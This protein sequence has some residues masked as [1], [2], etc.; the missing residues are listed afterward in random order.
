[1]LFPDSSILISYLFVLF[2]DSSIL[3]SYLFVLFPDSS[4]LI[5]SHTR[6]SFSVNS[7]LRVQQF[8]LYRI[9]P[10][11]NGPMICVKHEIENI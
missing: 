10:N 1:V 5:S 9:A 7:I 4:I 6:N 2:P 11:G 8:K 3:I